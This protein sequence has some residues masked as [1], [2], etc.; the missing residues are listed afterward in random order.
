MRLQKESQHEVAVKIIVKAEKSLR[1]VRMTMRG[2]ESNACRRSNVPFLTDV[3]C[4]A[5]GVCFDICSIS[6]FGGRLDCK[7]RSIHLGDLVQ[8]HEQVL[9]LCSGCHHRQLHRLLFSGSVHSLGRL[10]ASL[11]GTP[12]LYVSKRLLINKRFLCRLYH[13]ACSII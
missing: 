2:S 8:L 7:E 1:F 4:A 13:K 5:R 11:P 12:T 9:R 10:C 6:S 3:S